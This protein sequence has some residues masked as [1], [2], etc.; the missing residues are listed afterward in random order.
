[1]TIRSATLDDMDFLL[2]CGEHFAEAVKLPGGFDAVSAE[3]FFRFLIESPD[4]VLLIGDGGGVGGLAHPSPYNN[5]HKT[6]QELFWWVEPDKRGGRLGVA[7]LKALEEAV[8]ALGVQS[9]TVS[10]IGLD[11]DR[12]GPLFERWGYRLTDRNYTKEM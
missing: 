1:V 12:L 5:A 8:E 4:G 7:L 9:W 11:G 3:Q 2:L 6:G 10:S